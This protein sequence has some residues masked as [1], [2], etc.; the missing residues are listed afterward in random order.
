VFLNTFSQSLSRHANE[1]ERQGSHRWRCPDRSYLEAL[2]DYKQKHR[3]GMDDLWRFAR[4]CPVDR[5]IRPYLE[6]MT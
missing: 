6:A 1:T 5:V 2:R 3:S 4:I